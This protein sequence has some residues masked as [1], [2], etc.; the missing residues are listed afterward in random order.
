MDYASIKRQ[1]RIGYDQ[2]KN[3]GRI[4]YARAR[5]IIVYSYLTLNS[6][7]DCELQILTISDCDSIPLMG[8]KMKDGFTIKDWIHE[9]LEYTVINRALQAK[10]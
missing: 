2:L 7:F 8:L 1:G 3:E 9:F 10:L 5:L 4:P 6:S